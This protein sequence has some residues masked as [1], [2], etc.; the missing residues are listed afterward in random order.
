MTIQA[1]HACLCNS[2]P[3]ND[4][5]I[6]GT[7]NKP[8]ASNVVLKA[9]DRALVATESNKAFTATQIKNSDSP[10]FVTNCKV[11]FVWAGSEYCYTMFISRK[12]ENL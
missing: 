10:I 9:S 3:H 2:V 1:E 12:C 7:R 5:G 8:H 6:S 4:V 11:V